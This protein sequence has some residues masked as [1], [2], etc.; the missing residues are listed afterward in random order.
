MTIDMLRGFEASVP[1]IP[2]LKVVRTYPEREDKGRFYVQIMPSPN[3]TGEGSLRY[4]SV[5]WLTRSTLATADEIPSKKGI[6]F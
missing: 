5:V 6:F 2:F 1:Y 3:Q 4:P